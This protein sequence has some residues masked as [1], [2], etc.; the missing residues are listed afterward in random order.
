MVDLIILLLI[1]LISGLVFFDNTIGIGFVSQET[2]IRKAPNLSGEKVGKLEAGSEFATSGRCNETGWYRISYDNEICYISDKYVTEILPAPD[3]N[4]TTD[5][6]EIDAKTARD[7]ALFSKEPVSSTKVM[8]IAMPIIILAVIFIAG[9]SKGNSVD[10]KSYPD[11]P[12]SPEKD[13]SIFGID[14]D[15]DGKTS[16]ADDFITMDMIDDDFL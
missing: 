3:T 10:S 7:V 11:L 6:E 12:V 8:L 1:G 4:I 14:W 9:L 2:N 5:S 16:I 13:T 15:G